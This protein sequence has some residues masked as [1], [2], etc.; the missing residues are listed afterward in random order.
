MM[1]DM[2]GQSLMRGTTLAAAATIIESKVRTGFET[3]CD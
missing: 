2:R 1:Q 3:H